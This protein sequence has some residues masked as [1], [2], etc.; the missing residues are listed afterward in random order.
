MKILENN[1]SF[2]HLNFHHSKHL[3]HIAFLQIFPNCV[4]HDAGPPGGLQQTQHGPRIDS[5]DE[6]DGRAADLLAS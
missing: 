1:S 2:I 5:P 6:R 3:Y 4:L